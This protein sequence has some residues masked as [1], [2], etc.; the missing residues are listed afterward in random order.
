M[1]CYT[2]YVSSLFSFL[3]FRDFIPDFDD[4]RS[5]SDDDDLVGGLRRPGRGPGTADARRRDSADIMK[6]LGKAA[7]GE[8]DKSVYQVIIQA[9]QL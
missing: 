1:L 9:Q 8:D 4:S 5:S 3:S 2:K 7:D 6:L